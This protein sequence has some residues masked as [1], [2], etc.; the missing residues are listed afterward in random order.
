M[1]IAYVI[2]N[3]WVTVLKENNNSNFC[4]HELSLMRPSLSKKPLS[5][6]CLRSLETLMINKSF[7]FECRYNKMLMICVNYFLSDEV[8]LK[9]VW[10]TNLACGGE[11]RGGRRIMGGLRGFQGELIENQSSL[12]ERINGRP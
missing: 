9:F 2:H 1:Y 8:E 3:L 10:G 7:P 12:T 4:L 11:G 6:L 5:S